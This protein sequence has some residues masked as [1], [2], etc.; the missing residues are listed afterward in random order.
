MIFHVALLF[1][2]GNLQSLIAELTYADQ[3]YFQTTNQPHVLDGRQYVYIHH[4]FANDFAA[5]S[6]SKFYLTAID[7]F[8]STQILL[9]SSHVM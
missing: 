3:D 8:E 2:K 7:F 1:R 9:F 4:P 6:S 5:S